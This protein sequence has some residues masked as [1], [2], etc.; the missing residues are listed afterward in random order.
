MTD[1]FNDYLSDLATAAAQSEKT[2]EAA[3]IK[4]KTKEWFRSRLGKF[5]SSGMIDYTKEG[6]AKGEEFGETAVKYLLQLAMERDMTEEGEEEYIDQLMRKDFWQC[7][8]GEKYEPIARQKMAE[9]SGLLIMEASFKPHPTLVNFGGSVDGVGAGFV[10][11]IK[12]P[13]DMKIHE[14]N[15]Q[16]VL[17]RNVDVKH[18]YYPQWQSHL[19]VHPDASYCLFG[20]F[21]PRRKSPND[22]AMIEVYRNDDYIKWLEARIEKGEYAINQYLQHGIPIKK[23]LKQ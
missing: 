15:C 16:M 23:S 4:Q 10:C 17:T 22:L 12:C 2:I 19:M 3:Q 8:W 5:T 11:E 20:S 18:T 9:K 21:D 14:G 1:L 6:R 13:A 7:K